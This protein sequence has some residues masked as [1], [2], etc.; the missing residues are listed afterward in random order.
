STGIHVDPEP[1]SLDS[2]SKV[3]EVY[4][5]SVTNVVKSKGASTPSSDGLDVYVCA[6]LE[7]HVDIPALSKE[8]QIIKVLFADVLYLSFPRGDVDSLRSEL[9]VK[10]LGVPFISSRILNRDCK[11][12]VEKAK[13]RIGDWKN[14]SLSFAGRLQL[15]KLVI[16][17]MHVYWTSVLIIPKVIILDIQQLIHGFLWCNGEYKRGKAK[18]SW[19]DIFLPTRKGGL[20]L[21]SLEL[22]NM[23]FMT[24]HIW[25]IVSNKDSL[26]VHWIHTYKLKGCSFWH[27]PLKADMSWGWLKLL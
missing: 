8:L 17:S 6:I 1:N 13:N 25:N 22:F 23:A 10:Y 14:K 2:D 24:M 21:R 4:A 15:C 3:E 26:W 18:V 9:P 11:V 5:E 7:S 12:L 19:N 20:G 16:S 27:V